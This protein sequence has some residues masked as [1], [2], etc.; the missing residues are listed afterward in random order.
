MTFMDNLRYAARLERPER[1]TEARRRTFK[2]ATL[3]FNGGCSVFDCVVRDQSDSGA[4]LSFG[5]SSGVPT[6]FH[7]KIAGEDAARAA[8]VRW[9]NANT[10]GVFL[11]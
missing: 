8:V 10:I 11:G 1:R 7:L 3:R 6:R 4:R 5:D 9:R 2:G